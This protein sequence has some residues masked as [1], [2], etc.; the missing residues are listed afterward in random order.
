[1]KKLVLLSL[2]SIMTTLLWATDPGRPVLQKPLM[3]KSGVH[4]AS[5]HS[6]NNRPASQRSGTLQKVRIGKAGNVLSVLNA[7][8]H[9]LD[10]DST[11][12]TVLFIHRSDTVTGY[13]AANVA[14]YRY[15]ISRDGGATWNVNIGPLNPQADN[16]TINGRYPE[17]VLRYD[18]ANRTN[19][20]SALIVYNGS[21]HNGASPIAVWQGQYYGVGKLDGDPTSYTEH[22]DIV[23]NANVEIS[24]SMIQSIPGQYWNLNIDYTQLTNTTD[25]I[26]GLIIEHGVWNDS[27]KEVIWSYTNVPIGAALIGDGNGGFVGNNLGTPT[28]AFDPTGR[29]GWI[30]LAGDLTNDADFTTTPILM[31]SIDYGQT[32]TAPF[33][34]YL[35]N[36]PGLF[37]TSSTATNEGKTVVGSPQ[38]TVDSAGNPHIAAIIG[39]TDTTV[40][41]YGFFP[42]QEMDLY[43]LYFNPAVA[44]CSW[45]ANFLSPVYGYNGVYLSDNSTGDANR[46]QISRS[47]DGTKIFIFWTDTDSATVAAIAASATGTTAP[48][49]NPS[50]NLFGIGI[51][52]TSRQITNVVD[53]TVGD[54]DFGGATTVPAQA[55]GTFGGALF[56]VVSP[57]E[58]NRGAGVYNIP[59]VLTQPDYKNTTVSTWLSTNPAAFYFCQNINFNQSQFVNRFDNA[60]PTL[61]VNGPDTVYIRL[62]SAYVHPTASAYDCVF[63]NVNVRY[64]SNVPLDVNGNTD[65]VGIFTSTWT[66]TNGA[67]NTATFNQTVIV[68]APP[69]AKMLVTMTAAYY[70]FAFIDTS[71]NFP[72]NRTWYWGDGTSNNLNQKHATKVYTSG[73]PCKQVIL[74][75]WNQY[76]T[77]YDTVCV[78]AYKTGI[79]DIDLSDKMSVFPNPSSGIM[80]L[81]LNSDIAQGAKVTVLNIL[82]EQVSAPIEIKAGITSTVLDLQYLVS[83]A[84]MLKVE[85]ASGTGIKTI[86]INK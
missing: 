60:P 67:G 44:G 13:A 76:G 30:L 80:T 78:Q 54:A 66:A 29:Y 15:D 14:Q 28:I 10:V 75:V 36:L 73:G 47:K 84:Y 21:W 69:I 4:T 64:S 23:N 49:T 12:N 26:R 83:G 41:T 6:R 82:G 25:T 61:T 9:Q 45:Q 2:V 51:D 79:N 8:C 24:T 38:I 33:S 74:K 31:K 55:G 56:P 52:M 3:N 57:T 46:V 5:S 17:A 11:L 19:V 72:T 53:F 68:S 71:L 70:K 35:E 37:A 32:W 18:S 81:E 85:T 39:L 34:L 7:N 77:S 50:P 27:A 59:V 40:N 63:G 1:M 48:P 42:F 58:F 43:D 16:I 22:H 65:S 20:D 62:D 86:A